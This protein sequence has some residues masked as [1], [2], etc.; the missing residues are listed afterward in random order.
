MS[1]LAAPT[2]NSRYGSSPRQVGFAQR[3]PTQ[4]RGA[5]PGGAFG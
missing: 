1:N 4:G 5:V 3:N 2:V